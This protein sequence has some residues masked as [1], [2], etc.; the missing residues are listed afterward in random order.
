MKSQIF[1]C[2]ACDGIVTQFDEFC[3]HCGEEFN[4]AMKP[5]TLPAGKRKTLTNMLSHVL[6]TNRYFKSIPLDQIAEEFFTAG[7]VLLQEDNTEWSGMLLGAEGSALISLG[8]ASTAD[9]SQPKDVTFYTPFTNAALS[10]QWH[11]MPSG[12]YEVTAYVS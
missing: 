2:A 8:D 9:A 7:V 4:D 10:I 3:T 6:P 1:K 5:H 11:K 12:K